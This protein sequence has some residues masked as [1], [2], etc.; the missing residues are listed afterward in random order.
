MLAQE[1]PVLVEQHTSPTPSTKKRTF[2]HEAFAGRV[3]AAFP[4]P[5]ARPTKARIP[6]AP[7]EGGYTEMV[8]R[9]DIIGQSHSAGTLGR[10]ATLNAWKEEVSAFIRRFNTIAL[11]ASENLKA[12]EQTPLAELR[13]L[14]AKCTLIQGTQE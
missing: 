11:A 6:L 12:L 1:D 7:F 2:H 8:T 9:L 4:Q 14:C 10:L 5:L 3:Q 13:L